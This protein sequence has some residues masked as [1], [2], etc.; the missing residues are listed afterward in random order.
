MAIARFLVRM[1]L[2]LRASGLWLHNAT[3]QNFDAFLS[4]D[5]APTPSNLVQSKERK[6]LN[7]AIWQPCNENLP[8]RFDMLKCRLAGAAKSEVSRLVYATV[9]VVALYLGVPALRQR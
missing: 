8:S 9:A 4:L 3:L 2:A 1:D 6:G 5:C 7:F